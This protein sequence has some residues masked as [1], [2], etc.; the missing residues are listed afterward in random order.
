MK[1]MC[2]LESDPSV[3][4]RRPSE[5]LPVP[6]EHGGDGYADKHFGAG[7]LHRREN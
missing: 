6:G 1:T 7:E 2:S 3:I 5:P 4:E